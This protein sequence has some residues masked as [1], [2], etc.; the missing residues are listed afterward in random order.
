M[1]LGK[2]KEA[3]D[4]YTSALKADPANKIAQDGL[5]DAQAKLEFVA[6]HEPKCAGCPSRGGCCGG[7]CGGCGDDPMKNVGK[8]FEKMMENPE[9]RSMAEEARE[10]MNSGSLDFNSLLGMAGNIMKQPGMAEMLSNP[11]T[12]QFVQQMGQQM[13][14]NPQAMRDMLNNPQVQQLAQQFGLGGGSA[15]APQPPE[16]SSSSSDDEDEKMEN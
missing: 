2:Y 9:M 8:T 13:M 6:A 16:E 12:M 5:R 3:V 10:K 11:Q 7:G 1:S 4:A 14:S 15:P